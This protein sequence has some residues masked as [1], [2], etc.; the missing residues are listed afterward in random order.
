MS[1]PIPPLTF[2]KQDG[3]EQ[4]SV[5]IAPESTATMPYGYMLPTSSFAT[6]APGQSIYFSLPMDQV[7]NGWHVEIPFR[8]DLKVSSPLRSA[9][10]LVSLYQADLPSQPESYLS[11]ESNHAPSYSK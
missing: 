1:S 11:H 10:N 8:F 4:K 6:L 5:P 2:G 3:I 9:T 7:S